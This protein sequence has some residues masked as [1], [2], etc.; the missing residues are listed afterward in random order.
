MRTEIFHPNFGTWVCIGDYWAAG[1]TLFDVIVQ[2]GNMIQ[3]RNYNIKS[4]LNARA[5]RWAAENTHRFPISNVDLYQPDPD[6]EIC[7]SPADNDDVEV[8]LINSSKNRQQ[9]FW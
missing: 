8:V 3:Y 1:E 9:S 6:V 5:A 2:I 4:P 7:S